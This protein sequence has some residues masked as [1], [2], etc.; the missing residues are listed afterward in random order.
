MVQITWTSSVRTLSSSTVTFGGIR[1]GAA[2]HTFWKN[3][4]QPVTQGDSQTHRAGYL[5]LKKFQMLLERRPHT[6]PQTAPFLVWGNGVEILPLTGIALGPSGCCINSGDEAGRGRK[7]AK[8]EITPLVGL[9]EYIKC[10]VEK[11]QT[12]CEVIFSCVLGRRLCEICYHSCLSSLLLHWNVV[13]QDVNSIQRYFL[14]VA[15]R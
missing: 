2:I 7:V 8:E 10:A 4:V 12:N 15:E 1:L 9:Q 6:S 5:L 11:K 13:F 3:K 14:P